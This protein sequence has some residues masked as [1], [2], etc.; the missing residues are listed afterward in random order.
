MAASSKRPNSQ[1]TPPPGW[2]MDPEEL[3]YETDWAPE[4][5]WGYQIG[6]DYGLGKCIPVMCDPIGGV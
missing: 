3:D 5:S 1:A 6:V 4:G 2:S